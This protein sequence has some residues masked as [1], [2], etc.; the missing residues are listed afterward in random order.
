MFKCRYA[1]VFFDEYELCVIKDKYCS[2]KKSCT[3]LN[4]PR[5]DD[6]LDE[7][8]HSN[9]QCPENCI[10]WNP[11][12]FFCKNG[13]IQFQNHSSKYYLKSLILQNVNGD[14]I[15]LYLKRINENYLIYL[16]AFKSNLTE[17]SL[18]LPFPN[19]RYLNLSFNSIENIKYKHFS[20]T[21][22][23][24]KLILSN[25]KIQSIH[26]N[27]F[28]NLKYLKY[29][30]IK[31]SILKLIGTN[32]FSKLNILKK[33]KITFSKIF[34]IEDNLLNDLN[35]LEELNL[36]KT[37]LDNKKTLPKL[38]F[39]IH[40]Y[41]RSV[42]SEYYILCCLLK[43]NHNSV[44]CLPKEISFYSCESLIGSFSKKIIFSFFG[45]IGFFGN[46]ILMCQK[47]TQK[48]KP[49]NLMELMLMCS[50]FLLSI[51]FLSLIFMEFKFYKNYINHD[52]KW[53]SSN[54]C[55]I[56]ESMASASCL[57]SN[58]SLFLITLERYLGIKNFTRIGQKS[59]KE[60]V[61]L[62]ML[63]ILLSILLS[64]LPLLLFHVNFIL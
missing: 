31:N 10:Y 18:I 42:T 21:I 62:I 43:K 37:S 2:S 44:E 28:K 52:I 3:L 61:T 25:M 64:I 57:L 38:N 15:L 34:E 6:E 27:A 30:K 24:E 8:C 19:L 12:E 9:F 59:F 36:T 7:I 56:L 33:L 14:E 23:L 53:R 47:L 39:Q 41:L 20:K 40:K 29:F 58:F 4:C 35:N 1:N 50:D 32:I 60:I 46:L 5:G 13:K 11:G 54:F 16:N 45:L 17:N 49:L 51:F 48:L 22:F 26:K 63:A 55:K